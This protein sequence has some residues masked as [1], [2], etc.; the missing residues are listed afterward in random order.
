MH[1]GL[2]QYGSIFF[3]ENIFFKDPLV[4][5]GPCPDC[6]TDNRV[7]FGDVLGVEGFKNEA[8]LKCS[9]C[10]VEL[11]VTRSNLRVSSAPKNI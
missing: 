4:A 6:N 2:G 8:T 11:T 9:N 3:A 10:K 7:L 5:S 1:L